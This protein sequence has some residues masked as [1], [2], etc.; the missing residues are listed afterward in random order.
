MGFL[1]GLFLFRPFEVA[2][3]E[4]VLFFAGTFGGVGFFLEPRDR[5]RIVM[6]W[7][8]YTSEKV[9]IKGD[10]VSSP[11]FDSPVDFNRSCIK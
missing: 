11:F 1:S 5:V 9:Q 2:L 7:N 4:R 8:V 3:E 6:D 10:E